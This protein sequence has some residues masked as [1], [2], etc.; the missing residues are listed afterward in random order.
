MKKLVKFLFTIGVAALAVAACEQPEEQVQV[1]VNYTLTGD[2]SFDKDLKATFKVTA[3]KA[4]EQDITVNIVLEN[5]SNFPE[6]NL[7]FPSTIQIAK[8]TKE[9]SGTVAIKDRLALQAGVEYMA[10]FAAVVNDVVGIQKVVLKYSRPDLTG[11]WSAIGVLAGTNWTEDFVLTEGENG[12]YSVEGIDVYEGS[13]FKFRRDGAWDVNFGGTY[14]D[15]EFTV[16]QGGDNIQIA[17]EG[18]YTLA[19]NPNAEKAKVTRT[20]D[21]ARAYTLS[22]PEAFDANKKAALK[23]TSDKPV[24]SDVTITLALDSEKSNF[25]ENTLTVPASI[26]IAKGSTEGTADLEIA[27]EVSYGEYTAVVNATAGETAVGSVAVKYTYLPD[28]M[29]V[30]D[31]K[32]KCTSSSAVKFEGLFD[33]IY[34]NYIMPG[35]QHIYLED[36]TG[37]IRLY[38][39]SGGDKL[40]VGDKFSGVL[41]ISCLKDG[42]GRPQ[43]SE[44]DWW[45]YPGKKESAV[46]EMPK[47]V[48]VTSFASMFADYENLLLRRA[49]LTDVVLQADVKAKGDI[50]EITNAAGE[51]YKLRANFTI[52]QTFP[53]GTKVT[54]V[55]TVDKNGDNKYLT[56]FAAADVTSITPPEKVA[57]LEKLWG[58]YS[59]ESLWTNNV[60]SVSI[61]HP[62]GYGMARTLAMDDDYIYLP[63]SSAYANIAAVSI[64]NPQTQ[65]KAT[66]TGISGGSIFAT[67][68]AR[69]I[70]NT[71]ASVNGGKDILL[72]SNLTATNSDAEKLV[73]YAYTNGIS[74]APVVLCAFCWDS[75][76]SVN[77]WRRYGDRFFVT[78]TWQEGKLYFPSFDANKTVV[79]SV[80]NGARTAVTQ[81]AAGADNSPSGIKDLTV[82]PGSNSL[83]ITNA[84][85]ANL[86]AGTGS[87]TAQGWDEYTLSASSSKAKGT[88]GYNFFSYEGKNYIAYARISDNKAWIEV[89]IDKGDLITSLEAQEGILKAPL[90]DATNIDKE[91]ATGGVADCC[92][93]I[94][95]GVP[96][97]AA[98]TRDGGAAVCKMVLK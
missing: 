75:A 15:G 42:Q 88:W 22:G 28:K 25:P 82:Y 16:V 38:L 90:H 72:V 19:L 87:K 61:T 76:N 39:A 35:N 63:K 14:A 24:N 50:V 49:V 92:V 18:V 34:I 93:R 77:D 58:V 27:G 6:S 89:I 8:G 30:K 70:K 20:G 67:S 10:I 73:V 66:V 21:I 68:C 79:L 40:K 84:S 97:I 29:T 13:E 43:L 23:V 33:G 62:D 71:D 36:A 83:F 7:Q 60:Q 98:L 85:V 37:A 26:V 31:I 3:D 5:G 56:V 54:C 9:V 32:D 57:A 51:K 1:P 96:Y 64:T 4:V 69:M 47:P 81:I 91:H 59:G 44:F 46:D 45:T 80:A 53:K 94:I 2:A 11:K 48:N 52:P 86:V 78:G 95:N 65:S 17:A 55:G 12:W 41:K 74:A